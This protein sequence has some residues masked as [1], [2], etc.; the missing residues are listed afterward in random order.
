MCKDRAWVWE[1]TQKQ[2][3]KK[4]KQMLVASPVLALFDPNLETIIAADASSYGLGAVLL[5]KQVS[6]HLQLVAYMSRSMTPTEKRYT[7]IEKEALAF[8]W[9]CAFVVVGTVTICTMRRRTRVLFCAFEPHAFR[10][11]SEYV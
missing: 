2:A 4:V 8:T 9:A 3:F 10:T 1:D 5:Q 11:R 7:Q 6:G